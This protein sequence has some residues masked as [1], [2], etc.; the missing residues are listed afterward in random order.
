MSNL[1][2]ETTLTLANGTTAESSK[3]K[4]YFASVFQ[5][6]Q[7]GEQFV[8]NLDHVWRIGYTAK[9]SAVRALRKNFIEGVDYQS[10]HQLVER[11]IGGTTEEVFELTV[12]CLEY[13]VVRSNRDVFEVYRQCRQQVQAQTALPGNYKQAL[14]ALV[15]A[16]EEKEQ[17]QLQVEQKQLLL[18]ASAE[19]VEVLETTIQEAQPKLDKYNLFIAANEHVDF[20]TLAKNIANPKFGKNKM[21][22]FL[23]DEQI[24]M[25]DKGSKQN[26]PY[27]NYIEYFKVTPHTVED[28][29][30]IPRTSYEVLVNTKGQEFI[31]NR[32]KLRCIL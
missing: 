17:L 3:I 13:F 24:L 10:F 26:Y 29:N 23:R 14:L 19:K 1:T 18:T 21:L 5:A 28:R 16:E 20:E 8:V 32:A 31:V 2:T 25:K 4:N 11:G 12:S 6:E 30:G 27:S 7:T 22:K 9:S 15:A